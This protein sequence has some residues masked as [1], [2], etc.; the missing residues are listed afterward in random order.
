MEA[1]PGGIP[2]LFLYSSIPVVAF[3]IIES[4]NTND[5]EICV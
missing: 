4:G 1:G 3:H 2:S 5:C